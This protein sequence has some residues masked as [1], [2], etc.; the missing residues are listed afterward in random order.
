MMVSN[1]RRNSDWRMTR[2]VDTPKALK[3]PASY[4]VFL[5]LWGVFFKK[6]KKKKKYNQLVVDNQKYEY[7]NVLQRQYIP[8]P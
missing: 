4:I 2:V 1:E 8:R 5:K 6:K 3:I 7:L